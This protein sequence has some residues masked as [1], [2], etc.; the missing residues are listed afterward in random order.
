[1]TNRG[2][3]PHRKKSNRNPRVKKREAFAKAV[4]ARKGQVQDI[5]SGSATN[6]GGELTGIKANLSRSR[7]IGT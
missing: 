4:I 3:V 6:Y 1:M 5:K 2:L 7:K